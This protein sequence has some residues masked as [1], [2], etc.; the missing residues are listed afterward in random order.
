MKTDP[1]MPAGEDLLGALPDDML[2]F[3]LR[4]LDTR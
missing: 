1:S 4:R 3:L 2:H